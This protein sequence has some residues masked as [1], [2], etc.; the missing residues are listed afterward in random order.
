[1]SKQSA[2]YK[3]GQLMAKKAQ[4]PGIYMNG[5]R[6]ETPTP[7]PGGGLRVTPGTGGGA[8]ELELGTGIYQGGQEVPS[9]APKPSGIYMGGQQVSPQTAAPAPAAPA[10]ATE[11]S[12]SAKPNPTPTPGSAPMM[13]P[14]PA[15]TTSAQPPV[16][17]SPTQPGQERPNPAVSSS[18]AQGQQPRRPLPA[19]VRMP[20]FSSAYKLGQTMAKQA[21]DKKATDTFKKIASKLAKQAGMS[22]KEVA[23]M[24]K[25][26]IAWGPLLMGL[27]P[28][29]G[30]AGAGYQYGKRE[31][32]WDS[33]A[34]KA[35]KDRM[36]AIQM[37]KAQ[38]VDPARMG[39]IQPKEEKKKPWEDNK[40]QDYSSWGSGSGRSS[41]PKGYMKRERDIQ[42][43]AKNLQLANRH[44]RAFSQ[45]SKM[46]VY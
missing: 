5:Q 26:A 35:M 33:P 2:A 22:A 3:L 15:P 24:E 29:L 41:L 39:L 19:S 20:K 36:K 23:E 17:T 38:G 42:D 30:L 6:M 1:M 28:G 31:G 8:P 9:A 14:N 7:K 13:T 32:W 18:P 25:S 44:A 12:M 16:T 10:P 27:I 37:A 45:L 4:T 43:V 40:F 34:I 11:T 21:V 46:P